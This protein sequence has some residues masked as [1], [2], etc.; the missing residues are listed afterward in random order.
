MQKYRGQLEKYLTSPNIFPE[1]LD[2]QI[3]DL[4]LYGRLRSADLPMVI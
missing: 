4:L 1:K 2:A 3:K